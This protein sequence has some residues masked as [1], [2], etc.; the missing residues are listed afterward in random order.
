MKR[1]LRTGDHDP[2]FADWPGDHLLD[3]CKSGS[4]A[5]ADALVA[6][7]SRRTQD[8][9]TRGLPKRLELRTF[10]RAKVGPMVTGL[11]PAKERDVILDLLA[12]SLVFLARDNIE[13]VLHETRWPHTAWSLANLY[14][15]SVGAEGLDGKPSSFVGLS[16]ETTC[17][18]SLTYFDED[19]PFADFVVHEAAHVFHNWKRESVGLPLTRHREWLLQIDFAKREVFAYACEAYHRILERALSQADRRRLL[20]EYADRWVPTTAQVDQE[21]LVDIL[22]EAVVVRN[23]WKRILKRCAPSRR[24]PQSKRVRLIE[25]E[26]PARIELPERGTT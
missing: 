1:Y 2:I 6:E 22:S 8:R 18:V 20:A 9:D 12:D 11:F 25:Q 19:D 15:G 13:Q 5:L 3:R 24:I 10:S 26:R 14:L 23:G 7:V 17:Y 16:E 21:E 4:R